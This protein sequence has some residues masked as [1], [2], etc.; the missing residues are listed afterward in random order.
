MINWYK[1]YDEESDTK[2]F[3][4]LD[5]SKYNPY[6]E[7]CIFSTHY[8]EEVKEHY[9]SFDNSASEL[10]LSN[11]YLCCKCQEQ[12]LKQS[13][14]LR[15]V[16]RTESL[17]CEAAELRELAVK[18][19]NFFEAERFYYYSFWNAVTNNKQ[20]LLDRLSSSYNRFCK[21]LI[22][23]H[24]ALI[25][26]SE[27]SDVSSFSELQLYLAKMYSVLV[28]EIEHFDYI[29]FQLV[30]T[31]KF[32][33]EISSKLLEPIPF[34]MSKYSEKEIGE[35]L[36]IS[37]AR[38]VAEV[39]EEKTTEKMPRNLK[40]VDEAIDM[41]TVK[42]N[43]RKTFHERKVQRYQSQK[44]VID[45]QLLNK[46]QREINSLR[47]YFIDNMD[48]Q[49]SSLYCYSDILSECYLTDDTGKDAKTDDLEKCPS[50]LESKEFK[51]SPNNPNYQS[52]R[53]ARI[54]E[55]KKL[56]ELDEYILSVSNEY[57]E[58][59]KDAL[60]YFQDPQD[61]GS[62]TR[63]RRSP[64]LNASREPV[65]F[66]KLIL[67]GDSGKKRLPAGN[68]SRTDKA[69]PAGEEVSDESVFTDEEI[70]QERENG[71]VFVNL[72]GVAMLK[73]AGAA[74]EKLSLIH[75]CRCRRYAVCRSRW[76]PYH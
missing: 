45:R 43:L 11:D 16:F 44:Q 27:H 25:S 55:K 37:P 73:M 51:E 1:A 22:D 36:C 28:L 60:I 66:T 3:K 42:K 52:E 71:K 15:G 50:I 35:D 6:S 62:L 41:G 2:T 54:M 67:S 7:N 8:F 10:P 58:S 63:E 30:D 46:D 34:V 29:Y 74:G 23:L 5:Y 59:I 14:S 38:R 4:E 12:L 9:S 49:S 56:K 61:E 64:S 69:K 18:A 39:D 53:I 72:V 26:N 57:M 40:A 31:I 75:I 20:F 48:R 33:R 32:I 76:S 47:K 65:D 17:L 70:A 21:F 13:L 68:A 24:S 19:C